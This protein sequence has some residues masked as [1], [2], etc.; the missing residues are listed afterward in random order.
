MYIFSSV[1]I[2]DTKISCFPFNL[3]G[4]GSISFV[5]FLIFNTKLLKIWAWVFSPFPLLSLGKPL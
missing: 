3:S 2:Y 1:D 4:Y 5:G